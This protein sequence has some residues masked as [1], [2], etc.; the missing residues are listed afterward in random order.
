MSDQFKGEVFV[1]TSMERERFEQSAFR[2][3]W[4]VAT[5]PIM[6]ESDEIIQY[7]LVFYIQE[8]KKN[9]SENK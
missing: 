9:G 3:G 4:S 1:S 8:G 7:H 6:N 5:N 2:S